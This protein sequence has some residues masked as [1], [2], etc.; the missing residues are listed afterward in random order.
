MEVLVKYGNFSELIKE[1][2]I[3]LTGGSRKIEIVKKP[4]SLNVDGEPDEFVNVV[5]FTFADE[6][7]FAL[8]Q[9]MTKEELEDYLELLRRFILQL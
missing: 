1:A 9:E 7:D 5:K 2:T 8:T 6:L 4:T 3:P